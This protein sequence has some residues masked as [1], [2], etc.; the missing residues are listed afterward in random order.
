MIKGTNANCK[1]V[2][3]S[4]SENLATITLLIFATQA[5]VPAKSFR[6]CVKDIDTNETTF[7]NNNIYWI[8]QTNNYNLDSNNID[9][10]KYKEIILTL[11]ISKSGTGV[12]KDNR[13]VRSCFILLLDSSKNIDDEAAWS[14]GIINL[15]SSKF[16]APEIKNVSFETNKNKIKTKFSLIFKTKKNFNISD[17]N[18]TVKLNIKTLGTGTVLESK[19]IILNKDTPYNEVTT[20]KEY[21]I[22]QPII[23]QLLVINKNG[24]YISDI[25]RIYTPSKKYSNTWV[26]TDNGIKRVLF[27]YISTPIEAEHEGDWLYETN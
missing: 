9:T 6:I 5:T 3:I 4:V 13:W 22:G 21:T 12:I 8:D 25:N 15:I 27:I 23:I 10:K 7:I 16:E 26:K 2:N 1:I 11:D 20:D 17:K 19:E 24:E 18:F 14:S